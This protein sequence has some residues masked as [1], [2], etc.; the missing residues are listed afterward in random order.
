MDTRLEQYCHK[1][2]G[3]LSALP[4]DMQVH[5]KAL[6]TYHKDLFG[7]TKSIKPLKALIWKR[8]NEIKVG[9]YFVSYIGT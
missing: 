9:Q 4:S 1:E 2:R 8:W 3:A 7:K 5:L 6:N